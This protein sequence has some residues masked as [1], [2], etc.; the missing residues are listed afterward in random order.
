MVHFS[1]RDSHVV[2]FTCPTETQTGNTLVF[3]TARYKNKTGYRTYAHYKCVSFCSGGNFS[4]NGALRSEPDMERTHA[5]TQK[6]APDRKQAS[7][8]RL[9]HILL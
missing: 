6:P 3:H 7:L 2:I 4:F 8:K 9:W 5:Q 1:D